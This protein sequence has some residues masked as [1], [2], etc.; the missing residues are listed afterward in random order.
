MEISVLPGRRAFLR[1]AAAVLVAGF[2]S[3]PRDVEASCSGCETWEYCDGTTCRTAE[4]VWDISVPFACYSQDVGCIVRGGPRNPGWLLFYGAVSDRTGISSCVSPGYSEDIY[5]TWSTTDGIE[6]GQTIGEKTPP[7]TLLTSADHAAAFGTGA[8]GCDACTGW[9]IG[10]PAVVYGA[11]SGTWYMFYD[12]QSCA[13]A[14][15]NTWDPL[16]VATSSAWDRGWTIRGQI[17]GLPGHGPFSFP[18]IFRDPSDGRIYL[19]YHDTWVQTRVAELV[20]DGTGTNLV[21]L[22]GGLPVLPSA[23][24]DSVSVYRAA[25]AYWA[26]ADNFGDGTETGLNTLW[27]LGPSPTPI[28]FDWASREAVL[29]AGDWYSHKIWG[30]SAIGPDVTGDGTVRCY[31]WGA[32]DGGDNCDPDGS[33]QTGLIVLPANPLSGSYLIAY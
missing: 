30:P 17:T 25:G 29:G 23:T 14:G 13:S 7:L 2:L 19:Y 4:R 5:V 20:D 21:P 1:I 28:A 3:T 8:G 16:C 18:H 33:T 15:N 27:R 31:F 11:Q 32:G 12:S 26:I 24:V 22:N 9:H 6:F 10:D